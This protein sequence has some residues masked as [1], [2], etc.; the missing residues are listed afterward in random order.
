VARRVLRE[1]I[2]P[3][4]PTRPQRVIV[5]AGGAAVS[6]TCDIAVSSVGD[7]K[8]KVFISYSRKDEDFAQEL[9]AGLELAGFEPYLDKH[10]IAAGEDWEVRLGRL[11][12]AADTVVF[13]ISPDAVASER[14]AWEVERTETLKKRLLP[15]VWR[16]VEA[17]KVPVRLKRLNYIYFDKPHSFGPS[18]AALATALRTD[19]E[20]IREHTRIGEAVRR[21]DARGRAEAL[22]FRGDELAAAKAWLASPPQFAP[23]PTLLH[24]EFIKAAE[25]AEATRTSAERQR[26]VQ[27]RQRLV[28]LWEAQTERQKAQDERERALRRGQRALAAATGLLA[29]IILGGI[30]WYNQQ[31]LKDQYQWR[32]VMRPSVLSATREKEKAGKPSSDFKECSNGCPTMIVVPAGEFTM[33]SPDDEKGRSKDEAP[34]REV[35]ITKPFAA[36]H[37]LVPKGAIR[38]AMTRPSWVTTRGTRRTRRER[39]SQSAR[40]SRTP[41]ASTTCTVTY[42]SGSK[43][44]ITI[45]MRVLRRTDPHG[46]CNAVAVWHAVVPGSTI[47]TTS[48]RLVGAGISPTLGT[49][50]ASVSGGR[51]HPNTLPHYC[52]ESRSGRV[53]NI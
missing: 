30:G 51:L 18:A 27:E 32:M 6:S 22:L 7:R 15:I 50:A 48:G 4:W 28:Q 38:L 29:C 8:L 43:I 44:A 41:S 16:Q 23:E 37:G 31:F 12:E 13:V 35:T 3:S 1:T 26:L 24:H 2:R 11:I 17:A 40:K 14:C 20:W 53:P 33:G 46:L 42:G 39:L 49:T 5:I 34:Q 10:D 9:L 52:S 47:R 36:P 19:L 25:D 21:W 45:T